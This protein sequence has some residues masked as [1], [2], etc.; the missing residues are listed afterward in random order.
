MLSLISIGQLERLNLRYHINETE[1]S[2]D[3]SF[4]QQPFRSM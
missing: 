3:Y 4:N 2:C 1:K